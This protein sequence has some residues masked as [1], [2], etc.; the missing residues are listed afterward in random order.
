MESSIR[1]KTEGKLHL[2]K[3]KA[4]EIVRK[5]VDNAKSEAEGAGEKIAVNVQEKVS[6]I[7]QFFGK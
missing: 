6:Q 1:E 2:V 3:G 4:R 5:L 7:K